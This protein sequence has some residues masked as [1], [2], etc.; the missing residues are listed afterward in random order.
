LC[1]ADDGP[2]G[3]SGS[4]R[5]R[6]EEGEGEEFI[7]SGNW[8][9]KHKSLSRG[10]GETGEMI[11]SWF[12]LSLRQDACHEH[13]CCR[14]SEV[15]SC[16]RRSEVESCCR[17]S[18]V[19][20]CCRR[21]EV[22]SCREQEDGRQQDDHQHC[23]NPGK[24]QGRTALASKSCVLVDAVRLARRCFSACPPPP[25]PPPTIALLPVSTSPVSDL[26]RPPPIAQAPVLLL[27]LLL[28]LWTSPSCRWN[29]SVYLSDG[30]YVCIYN[31]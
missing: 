2:V 5:S 3:V 1:S 23:V 21:S 24:D 11:K 17:R 25:P 7:I 12:E 18:E 22:E 26:L 13:P 14:R 8:R 4:M 6:W 31:Q 30:I 29:R 15:E 9:G 28:F 20:S 16:C 27:L 10:A 19:E